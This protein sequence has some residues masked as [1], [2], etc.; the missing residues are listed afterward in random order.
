MKPMR[1]IPRGGS[2]GFFRGR[3]KEATE[4][5]VVEEVPAYEPGG[6]G[7]HVWMWIEKRGLS[8]LDLLHELALH[9]ECDERAFGIA[10]LKDA[11]A[12]SRQWVSLEHADERRCASL[13]GERFAVLRTS[14][15]GNK[16]RMG[17][18]RGN[19]FVVVLRGTATGDLGKAQQNLAELVRLGVPN[20]FGEQRFGKRGANLQKGIDV[21][22]GNARA[23]AARMPRRVFGLVISAVQSDVFNRVVAARRSALGTLQAG[24]LAFLHKNGAVFAVDDA[25]REQPRA[26]SFELSP[27]GPMPGPEMPA[28]GGEVLAIEQDALRQLELT[29]AD[30]E[31]LPFRLARGERRPL[32]VPVTDADASEVPAGLQLQFTLPRGAYATAV[33]RELLDQTIWFAGN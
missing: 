10:G 33:L 18:L 32:R 31:G 3:Y 6:S 22:R 23:F 26:D 5:F 13:R 12:I 7:D 27:T 1:P 28:P 15:H 8:T 4:D 2:A 24:D 21:L 11:Q 30:F 29:P 17:H 14:R 16:L 20:Y 25:A 19:R 9:L